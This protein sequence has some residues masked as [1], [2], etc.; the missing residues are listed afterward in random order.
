[1]KVTLFTEDD[2]TN[3]QIRSARAIASNA[4]CN[5]IVAECDVILGK[6]EVSQHE[7]RAVARVAICDWLNKQVE[8]FLD[9]K[10]LTR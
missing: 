8:M 7:R 6:Y 3:R 9:A 4:C 10:G 1:M 2:I 5:D